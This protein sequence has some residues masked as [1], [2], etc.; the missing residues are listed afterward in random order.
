MGSISSPAVVFAI[1][2]LTVADP[3]RPWPGVSRN[4][5]ARDRGLTALASERWHQWASLDEQP[6]DGLSCLCAPPA[7]LSIHHNPGAWFSAATRWLDVGA[8][9]VTE[10][11]G[12]D[13]VAAI[14]PLHIDGERV[15]LASVQ[16]ARTP[17]NTSL[18]VRMI[19]VSRDPEAPTDAVDVTS[20]VVTPINHQHLDEIAAAHGWGLLGRWA[21]WDGTPANNQWRISAY[22]RVS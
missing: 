7:A 18:D 6:P 3:T 16:R 10:E 12:I 22:R 1:D 2:Q 20:V 5:G 4:V 11:P 14:E 19:H 15:V 21:D 13:A 9:L 8:L 17:N